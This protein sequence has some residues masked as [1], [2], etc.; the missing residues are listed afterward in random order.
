MPYLR[1]PRRISRFVLSLCL[2][3]APA[4]ASQLTS[5]DFSGAVQWSSGAVPGLH[6][7]TP[8][9]GSF[10]FDADLIPGAGSG[11]VNVSFPLAQPVF[12]LNIGPAA[13]DFGDAL[14]GSGM[15]QYANGKFNG[16]F[17]V[18]DF[19]DAGGD[20]QLSM[21]GATWSIYAE[22]GGVPTDVQASGYLNGTLTNVQPY[23]LPTPEPATWMSLGSLIP[24]IWFIRRKK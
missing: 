18:A 7:N 9:S 14:D 21:Q 22:V 12:T 16:F 15:V 4:L 24:A 8:A 1:N 13:F 2:V 20:H 10:V 19:S 6:W 5:A 17:F 23:S 3:S 11:W